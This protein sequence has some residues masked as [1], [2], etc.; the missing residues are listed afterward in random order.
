MMRFSF[1]LFVLFLALGM[2]ATGACESSAGSPAAVKPDTS[3]AGAIVASCASETDPGRFCADFTG[4]GWTLASTKTSCANGIWSASPCTSAN[5]LGSCALG[6]T[7]V[8]AYINRLYPGDPDPVCETCQS[9]A[10][11][12][13]THPCAGGCCDNRQ[14][15][16]E[17]AGTCS[18]MPPGDPDCPLWTPN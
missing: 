18:C 8:G 7:D 2:G 11:C 13:P 17:A 6:G 4:S 10:D 1:V 3:G 12:H 9:D 16:A 5:R 15:A 14:T